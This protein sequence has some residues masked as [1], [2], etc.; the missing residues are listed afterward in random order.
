MVSISSIVS[1]RSL[2]PVWSRPAAVGGS[3]SIRAETDSPIAHVRYVLEVLYL[4]YGRDGFDY[5]ETGARGVQP[6][7]RPID[8]GRTGALGDKTVVVPAKRVGVIAW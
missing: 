3:P 4:V 8:E 6:L 2:S 5:L 1:S 7:K